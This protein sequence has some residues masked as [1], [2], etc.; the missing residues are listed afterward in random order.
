M[1]TFLRL[2]THALTPYSWLSWAICL[3]SIVLFSAYIIY[4]TQLI[5]G[6]GKR[7]LS[8]DDYILGAVMLYVDIV[9]LFLQ[10]LRLLG[11]I[12]GSKN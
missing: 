12:M 3:F 6:K 1:F 9:I 5:V 7:S 11:K 2:S 10:L 4:D 8:T